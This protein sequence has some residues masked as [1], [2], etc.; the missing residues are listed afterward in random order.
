[1]APLRGVAC[2]SRYGLVGGSVSLGSGFEV[3]SAQVTSCVCL[4]LLPAGPGVELSAPSPCLPA[5][6]HYNNVLSSEMVSHPQLHVFF[7]K[8]C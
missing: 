3:T 2:W 6:Y 8:S 1:M 5:F 4:F 7:F